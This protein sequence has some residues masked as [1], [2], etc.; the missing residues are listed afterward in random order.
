MVSLLL[1]SANDVI[2]RVGNFAYALGC[3]QD[4]LPMAKTIGNHW[5]AIIT[6]DY[7]WVP[8]ATLRT[9]LVCH[10]Y[11]WQNSDRTYY[12]LLYRLNAGTR[13]GF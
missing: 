11:H 3:L 13:L 1:L 12:I 5:L 6:N 9:A 7:H 2:W 4:W 10:C 8:V